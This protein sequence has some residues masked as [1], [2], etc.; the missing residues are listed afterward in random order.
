MFVFGRLAPCY[1]RDMGGYSV[2]GVN[3]EMGPIVPPPNY[4][5]IHKLTHYII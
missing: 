5:R 4:K 2:K 1:L 3:R